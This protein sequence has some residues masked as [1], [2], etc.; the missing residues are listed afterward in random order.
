MTRL[1]IG[2]LEGP[3]TEVESAAQSYQDDL[4]W[5]VGVY[6]SGV[7]LIAGREVEALDMPRELAT[8]AWNLL[9]QSVPV[10]E[11]SDEHGVRWA[12]ITK[13]HVGPTLP[14]LAVRG[15]DHIRSGRSID[16]P[17]SKYGQHHLRWIT[18]PLTATTPRFAVVADAVLQAL[19]G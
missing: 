17:P 7:W 5:M 4:G 15:V 9:G 11:S 6:G 18:S 16:L 14:E 1:G 8:R 13:V 2:G 19:R 3:Q 12:F 10:F